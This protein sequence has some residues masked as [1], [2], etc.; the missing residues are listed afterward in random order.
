MSD[1]LF[2][3]PT[4]LVAAGVLATCLFVFAGF[5]AFSLSTLRDEPDNMGA[6]D[7]AALRMHDLNHQDTLDVSEFLAWNADEDLT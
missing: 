4:W 7:R 6:A 5:A 2:G 1:F 3:L